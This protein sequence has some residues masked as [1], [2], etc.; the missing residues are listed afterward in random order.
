M[1]TAKAIMS[2]TSDTLDRNSSPK[3][4]CKAAER[5]RRGRLKIFLGAAR[6][7]HD[8]RDDPCRHHEAPRES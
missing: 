7:R 3:M 5:K 2:Q 6:R 8:L 4:P 1:Q